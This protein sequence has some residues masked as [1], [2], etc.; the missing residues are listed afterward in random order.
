MLAINGN[1]CAASFASAA[2]ESLMNEVVSYIP[3]LSQINGQ[4]ETNNLT[5]SNALDSVGMILKDTV[6]NGTISAVTGKIA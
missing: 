2:S 1:V 6:V 4:T 3:F 5:T